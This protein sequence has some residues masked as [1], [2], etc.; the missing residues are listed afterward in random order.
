MSSEL[1]SPEEGQTIPESGTPQ[2]VTVKAPGL[3]PWVTYS[4]MG[5]TIALFLLQMLT[6]TIFGRDLVAFWGAKVNVYILNGQFWRLFTPMLL[7]GSIMHI[8]FNMYALYIFGPGLERYYGHVRFFALYVLSGFAGNVLSMVFTP[9]TSLGSSTAIFGLLA[10]QGV[11][12]YQNQRLFGKNAQRA[13]SQI[14]V[15]AVINFLIGLSPAIDNWGHLGGFIGGLSFSWMAGPKLQVTGDY[16]PFGL[17][18]RRTGGE[19]M[20]ATIFTGAFLVMLV[21]IVLLLNA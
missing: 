11:F 1:H 5:V 4:F 14:A 3:K 21:A 10:A 12:F 16:P 9:A 15:I 13:L 6:Q 20:R 19:V 18:D 2:W 17:E 8:G 7:H